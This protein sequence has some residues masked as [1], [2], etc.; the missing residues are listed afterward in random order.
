MLLIGM[1]IGLLIWGIGSVIIDDIVVSSYENRTLLQYVSPS[2]ATLLDGTWMKEYEDYSCEQVIGREWLMK[3][4]YS[5]LDSVGVKERNGYVEGKEGYLFEVKEDL[6]WSEEEYYEA[7]SSEGNG[8]VNTATK[9]KQVAEATGS[10]L[11]VLEVPHKT[12]FCAQYYPQFWESAEKA[13][14]IKNEITIE[15]LEKFGVDIVKTWDVLEAHKEEELYYKTDHHYTYL[16]AYYVYQELLSYL[17]EVYGEQLYFPH[18]NQCEQYMLEQ[19]MVGSYLK[20]WGDSG[21]KS[22]D[23]LRWFMPKDM[24]EYKRY[25][26][27]EERAAQLVKE[28]NG[29]YSSFMGGDMANTVIKTDRDSLPSILFI[30]RSYTNPLEVM[31]AYSFN[32]MH[33]IDPRYYEG[34]ISQYIR[35][36]NIDYVVMVRFDVIE[37]YSIFS[38]DFF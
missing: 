28:E 24:P 6:V 29:S 10:K 25:E 26:K 18:P 34:N 19:R 2:W 35:E 7:F 1:L 37:G 22:L 11:I 32:E 38:C 36:N 17:N 5:F 14:R 13:E 12:Q 20:T 8:F 33:S 16:G 9:L 21:K 4:Y 3:K 27:G 23:S 30:G 31:A 15:K